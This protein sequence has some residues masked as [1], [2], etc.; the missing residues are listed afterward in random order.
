MSLE[1]Q[2]MNFPKDVLLGSWVAN[3]DMKNFEK[4]IKQAGLDFKLYDY[5]HP[6]GPTSDFMLQYKAAKFI[7]QLSEVEEED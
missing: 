5:H 3:S 4:I 1:S 7:G 2:Q 6:M